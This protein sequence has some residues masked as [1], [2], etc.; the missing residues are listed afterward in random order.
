MSSIPDQ[1]P[2]LRDLLRVFD[3][4]RRTII[5]TFLICLSLAILA[6]VFM[7]R[8]Y[9]AIGTVQLQ[10]STSDGLNLDSLMGGAGADGGAGGASDSLSVNVDLQTQSSILQSDTLALKVI[11]DLSLE[12]NRDFQE[13][14]S[15]IGWAVG[16]ITPGGSPD[17]AHASLEDSPARRQRV[18]TVFG[19]NLKVKTIAGTRLIEVDYSN[20]DPKIAADVVNHLVQ[21]LIDYTFQTKFVATNEVSGWLEGQLGGL[22]K[23][24]EDLQTKVVN[25]QKNTGLFG[26]GGTDPQGKPIIYSPI[27]D[28]LTQSTAALS[29]A[30]A[31]RVLKGAVY[32]VVK[33]GNA[34]LISQLG[35]TS[36]GASSAPGAA[37]SLGLIQALRTQEATIE[38]Q[39]GQDSAKFGSSYPRLI[40]ERASLKR[41]EDS[42]QD[43]IQRIAARAK[44]DYEV[45]VQAEEGARRSYEADRDAAEKLNDKTIEYAILDKEATQSQDLYQD[46]LRRLKEAGILE[47]LRSSNLTVVDKA[48][49]PAKPDRPNVP[50]FLALG[51]GLGAFSSACSALFVDAIDNKVQG[52]EEIESARIPVLGIL[53]KIKIEG[54]SSTPTMLLSAPTSAFSEAIRSLRSAL[55]IARSGRPPQVILVTSGSPSEGKSTISLNLAAALAQFGKRVLLVEA[56]LRRPVLRQRLKVGATSGL[57]SLLADREVEFSPAQIDGIP[58]LDFLPAGAV[59]PYPSELL[60]SHRM[61]E[62]MEEWRSEYDFI[63]VDCPPVLPVTDVQLIVGLADATVLVV[64]AGVTTRVALQRAYKLLLPHAKDPAL[65]AIGAV[66]NAISPNSAS[67]YGYYGYYGQ[68]KSTY[69]LE[70]VQDEVV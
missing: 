26:V 19:N 7:T 5:T 68:K 30:Q 15:L 41:V 32:Q 64:R 48:R 54:S 4:R 8:R 6:C 43:E 50:L 58:M 1:D 36:V 14:F 3:R 28:R 53:P 47:G 51:I 35:G 37:N 40:E 52:I 46:L 65:P 57:S 63:V 34:E 29:Q 18:L 23:Q 33:T 31:N 66:L 44:N 21:A 27:L 10:K 25:L 55:F 20:P 60:G 45:A 62:L 70:G 16:L 24:S 42:L 17:P 11:E 2:T 12:H 38:A 9:Q 39:I 13:K 69:Y 22:R 67:Y 56:D 61:H 49:P 59:P